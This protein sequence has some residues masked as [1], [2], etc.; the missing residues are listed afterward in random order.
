MKVGDYSLP[1]LFN[2]HLQTDLNLTE[3]C[4]RRLSRFHS[5]VEVNL[6][7]ISIQLTSL[8]FLQS[9]TAEIR[10]N[11]SNSDITAGEGYYRRQTLQLRLNFLPS[12]ICELEEIEKDDR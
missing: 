11:Y 9:L 5:T 6:L 2:Q 12:I 3:A 1:L 4:E 7:V 8:I 10:I